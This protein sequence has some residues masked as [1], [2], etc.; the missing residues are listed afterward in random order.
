MNWNDILYYLGWLILSPGLIIG[1]WRIALG[2][3]T[4]DRMVGFDLLTITVVGLII[5]VSVRE[6]TGDYVELIIIATALSFFS[7]VAFFYYL[8]HLPATEG[9]LQAEK[10]ND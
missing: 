8:S 2:P 5:L 7:T 3:T 4:L 1:V 6:G 9:E 10:E